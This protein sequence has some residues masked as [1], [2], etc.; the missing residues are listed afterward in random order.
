MRT[1][2]GLLVVGADEGLAGPGDIVVKLQAS[3]TG[4]CW[5]YGGAI[6]VWARAIKY[7]KTGDRH[8]PDDPL[9]PRLLQSMSSGHDG[10][11][12]IVLGDHAT[13]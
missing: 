13:V 6:S 5:G 2:D 8:R 9:T 4:G 11:L 1:D 12:D 10:V 7:R 3:Q